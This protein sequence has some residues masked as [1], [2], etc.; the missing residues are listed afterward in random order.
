MS[1]VRLGKEA[2]RDSVRIMLGLPRGTGVYITDTSARNAEEGSRSYFVK[3]AL[4]QGAS[5]GYTLHQLSVISGLFQTASVSCAQTTGGGCS[6]CGSKTDYLT[7]DVLK[8]PIMLFD[9]YVD[10]P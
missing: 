10:D 8:S 5:S 1:E 9:D 7:F 2:T 6:T 3:V 4:P